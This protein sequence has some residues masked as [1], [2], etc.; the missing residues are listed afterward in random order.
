MK[1]NISFVSVLVTIFLFVMASCTNQSSP[2]GLDLMDDLVGTD[3]TDTVTVE[4]YS[5]LE[6]T[7]VTSNL[8]ANLVGC[9]SDPVFGNSHA[10]TLAQFQLSGASVNFGENPVID[11]VVLTLQI[12]GYYGDTT[13]MC[14]IRVYRL[15]E[16]MGTDVSYYQNSEVGYDPTPL[17]Y[18]LQ[19]YPISPNTQVVVDTGA[20]NPHLRIRL[21]QSFG[22]YLLNNQNALN[23]NISSVFKGLCI[24]AISHTGSVG[25]MFLTNINSALSGIMLYYHNNSDKNMRYQLSCT[26]KSAHYTKMSHS[27]S[28]SQSS[29]FVSEV[30]NGN[31]DLGKKVLFLQGGGGVKTRITFPHLADAFASINDRVVIHRA[32]L[33][34]TNVRPDE[35]FLIQ[36]AGLTLQ[37]ITKDG[38]VNFIPDDDYYTSASYYGGV[39]DASKHEYRF[40]ITRYVQQLVLK[41]GDLT[42]SLNLVVRGAGIRPNRL[43]LGGT[44]E[45]SSRLR[46]ELSYSTY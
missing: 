6:D 4:A 45:N 15:T 20:Y 21:S 26:A 29:D 27:Y 3:F 1:R 14:G 36:P 23:T 42:N 28:A 2:I 24:D 35:Q 11:S 33:V 40:R 7:V 37:G 41:Q 25:Y 9:I 8:S 17:N 31:K 12:S 43:V 18:S 46:L 16:D 10:A 30:L 5:V 38:K 22:Q 39:Y 13:S 34:I 44:E 19:G 32:E